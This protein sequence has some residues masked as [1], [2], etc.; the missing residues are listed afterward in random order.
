MNRLKKEMGAA[1]LV[2]HLRRALVRQLPEGA[3]FPSTGTINQIL[4]GRGATG[5]FWGIGLNVLAVLMLY[6]HW[7]SLVR[8]CAGRFE[9][10]ASSPP[11][12]WPVLT[13][14]L[15]SLYV[16]KWGRCPA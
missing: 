1:G 4:A 14:S 9:D 15:Y 7:Y 8:K 11:L 12:S 6:L 10:P 13:I 5:L 2:L 16:A 3:K